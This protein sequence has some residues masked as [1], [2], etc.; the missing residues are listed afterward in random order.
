[1]NPESGPR[2]DR[3]E[4]LASAILLLIYAGMVA[5]LIAAGMSLTV[6]GP[7]ALLIGAVASGVGARSWLAGRLRGRTLDGDR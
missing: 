1:M 3:F 5:L 6:I 4:Y 7:L 2:Q